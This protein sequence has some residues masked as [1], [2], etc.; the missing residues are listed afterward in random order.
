MQVRPTNS[1][2]RLKVGADAGKIPAL[3]TNGAVK[4]GWKDLW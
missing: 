1:A 3:H 4:K 2:H